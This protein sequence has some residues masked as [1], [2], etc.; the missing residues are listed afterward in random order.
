MAMQVMSKCR[1][2]GVHLSVHDIL[3]SK[4]ISD[5]AVRATSSLEAANSTGVQ[6]QQKSADLP[7]STGLSSQ[8]EGALQGLYESIKKEASLDKSDVESIAVA[9]D[10]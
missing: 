1:L 5:L 8:N 6:G 9:S 2:E 3:V 4:T 10:Y 7:P